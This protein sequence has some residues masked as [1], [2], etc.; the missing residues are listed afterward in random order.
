MFIERPGFLALT[1]LTVDTLASRSRREQIPWI[2]DDRPRGS[3]HRMSALMVVIIDQL[4]R[5]F[6]VDVS[7][8]ARMVGSYPETTVNGL[9]LLRQGRETWIAWVG[10]KDIGVVGGYWGTPAEIFAQIKEE[11]DKA[12]DNN[13]LEPTAVMLV[14][15]GA[16]MNILR[17][18]AAQHRISLGDWA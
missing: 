15:L 1:G 2:D 4:V 10:S 11:A 8:A 13:P 16:A 5:S 14:D 17:E 12:P 9:E 18:R 3:Y 6:E 7:R